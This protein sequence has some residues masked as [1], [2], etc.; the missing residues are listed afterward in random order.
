MTPQKGMNAW[1]A[2]GILAVMALVVFGLM[3]GAKFTERRGT[4]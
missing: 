2:M 3:L 1:Q 4:I